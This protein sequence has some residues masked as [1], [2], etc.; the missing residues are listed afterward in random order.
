MKRVAKMKQNGRELQG[1][2]FWRQIGILESGSVAKMQQSRFF[3]LKTR[4]KQLKL[5]HN[6]QK[7]P[8]KTMG[9]LCIMFIK[10]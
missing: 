10:L 5:G 7:I 8:G 4:G 3:A 1:S 2:A 9:I 6:M